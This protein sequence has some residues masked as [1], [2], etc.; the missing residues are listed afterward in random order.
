MEKLSRPSPRIAA[1]GRREDVDHGAALGARAAALRVA[2]VAMHGK[3]KPRLSQPAGPLHVCSAERMSRASALLLATTLLAIGVP[4]AGA[5]DRL[6]ATPARE[7]A[8]PDLGSARVPSGPCRAAL[9]Q[10][11]R[12]LARTG[13]GVVFWTRTG[14]YGCLFSS[15]RA[16]VL[17]SQHTRAQSAQSARL[18]GR[19]AAIRIVHGGVTNYDVNS[20]SLRL[21]DLRAGERIRELF[22]LVPTHAR[23][24]VHDLVAGDVVRDYVLTARGALAWIGFADEFSERLGII[25]PSRS[26]AGWAGITKLLTAR[27]I[28]EPARRSSR[29][30]FSCRSTSASSAGTGT[31]CTDQP[32]CAEA[33]Q[34]PSNRPPAVSFAPHDQ[35]PRWTS[36]GS[37]RA[38]APRYRLSSVPVARPEP[39]RAAGS[40]ASMS[41][42]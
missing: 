30:P 36:S 19:Y 15:R 42:N 2:A 23:D 20:E 31:A 16:P 29:E 27:R 10:A 12:V 6:P 21:F 37:S 24:V 35:P 38:H 5:R 32:R 33:P 14:T 25:C 1:R 11:T 13:R 39:G 41:R 22:P 3:R 4:M 28:S 8:A 9:D 17:L 7:V 40:A 18:A 34:R 26:I